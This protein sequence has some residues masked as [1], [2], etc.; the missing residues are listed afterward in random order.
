[1]LVLGATNRPDLMDAALLRAGRFDYVLKL[2]PPDRKERRQILGI[3]AEGLPLGEDVNLERLA[4]RT[5]GFTGADLEL[6][7][8]KAAI[9]ALEDLRRGR[10]GPPSGDFR[11]R[12]AHVREAEGQ[13]AGMAA[14]ARPSPRRRR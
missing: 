13:V 12:G 14:G 3:H 4:D 11:I 10:P 2:A 7:C 8:K 1:V 9:L 5:A 6:L